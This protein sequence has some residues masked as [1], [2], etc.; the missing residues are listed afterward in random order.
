MLGEVHTG[1]TW[2]CSTI[3]PSMCGGNAAW[4]QITVT[5]CYYY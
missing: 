4:C 3:K 5:T 2:P 1:T